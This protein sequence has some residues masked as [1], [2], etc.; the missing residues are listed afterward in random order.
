LFQPSLLQSFISSP[1]KPPKN[2]SPRLNALKVHQLSAETSSHSS[3]FSPIAT[4]NLAHLVCL[5]ILTVKLHHSFTGEINSEDHLSRLRLLHAWQVLLI[6][7]CHDQKEEVST[8]RFIST[9]R[10][11]QTHRGSKNTSPSPLRDPFWGEENA[12]RILFQKSIENV[13]FISSRL[14]LMRGVN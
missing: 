13:C 8:T 10:K 11:S 9:R 6:T 1:K 5:P 3:I 7:I 12:I 4:H 14:L 2:N